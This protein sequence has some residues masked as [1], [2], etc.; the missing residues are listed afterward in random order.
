[1]CFASH[2]LPEDKIGKS[3]DQTHQPVPMNLKNSKK[4]VDAMIHSG[5]FERFVW[6]VIYEKKYNFHPRLTHKEFDKNNP[7]VL[8]KVE[9]QITVG[10]SEHDF[11]LFILR[12]YIVEEDKIDKKLLSQV[13]KN[14][15]P[16]QKKYKGL[17]NCEDLI[18]Y[19]EAY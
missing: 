6:S 2:W 19:L 11:C 17:D 7:Q 15:T 12:Q 4:I 8:L 9:R 10:F 3:F 13:I 5:I 18:N 16:E 1:V 14:M